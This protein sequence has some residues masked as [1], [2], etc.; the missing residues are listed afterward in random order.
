MLA[1]L[2]KPLTWV[3]IIS[4]IGLL[5]RRR[6]YLTIAFF[7]LLIFTNPFLINRLLV[8]W[9]PAPTAITKNYRIAIVLTGMTIPDIQ[10]PDQLQTGP[11]AERII[12]PVR[13][14]HQQKVQSILISG[15]SGT[16]ADSKLT[17]S[18]A[19]AK[20]S[21]DLK[22]PMSDLYVESKSRNT[23]QNALYSQQLLDSLGI[24]DEDMLLVTSAFHMN[25]SM[26]CFEKQGLNPTPYPV[27]F[28]GRKALTFNSIT[29]SAK[30]LLQW[31]QLIHEWIGLATY[32]IRGYI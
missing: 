21:S 23:Y 5:K 10:I 27:D 19:L 29:P 32:K 2:F 28:N 12:E 4:L 15:G 9:E 20:L 24:R 17:E 30:S 11:G 3:I 8:W 18:P 1:F 14:Y 7:P 31:D 22:V 13:L 16:L 6:S 26:K 25:R